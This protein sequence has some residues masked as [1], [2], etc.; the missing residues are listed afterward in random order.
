MGP[1]AHSLFPSQTVY[2][3]RV[4]W[5][6]VPFSQITQ[7]RSVKT[8]SSPTLPDRYW[9]MEK[10]KVRWGR[11]RRAEGGGV[12]KSRRSSVCREQSKKNIAQSAFYELFWG[13]L[14]DPSVRRVW[15]CSFNWCSAAWLKITQMGVF[16]RQGV[17]GVCVCRGYVSQVNVG[18]EGG[19]SGGLLLRTPEPPCGY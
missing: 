18:T 17:C 7:Q 8:I 3:L 13:L 1:S 16:W 12:V 2:H 15:F 14:N 5:V 6:Q 4:N 10:T 11:E 19:A 9:F